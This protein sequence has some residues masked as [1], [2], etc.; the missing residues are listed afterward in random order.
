LNK[1]GFP[2]DFL[3]RKPEKAHDKRDFGSN[4]KVLGLGEK[5]GWILPETD[6]LRQQGEKWC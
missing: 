6:S 3:W 1:R 2:R 4:N 5:W